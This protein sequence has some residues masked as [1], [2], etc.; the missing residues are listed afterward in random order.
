MRW[1]GFVYIKTRVTRHM[2]FSCGKHV[3]SF[4]HPVEAPAFFLAGRGENK[5]RGNK[6]KR[7][8]Q[9]ASL[10]GKEG[11]QL[12]S[13][14]LLVAIQTQSWRKRLPRWAPEYQSFAFCPGRRK[15]A[16]KKGLL[17]CCSSSLLLPTENVKQQNKTPQ[18]EGA[19]NFD[20]CRARGLC[21]RAQTLITSVLLARER[22]QSL[23]TIKRIHFSL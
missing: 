6:L 8:E 2:P 3:L 18:R 15:K 21:S 16:D 1:V 5:R 14:K 13:M 7:N 10:K 20:S 4:C 11:K 23:I 17:L 12:W 19:T 22:A 9:E